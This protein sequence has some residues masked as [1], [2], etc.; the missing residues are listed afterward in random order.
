MKLSQ[1][2]IS[3]VAILTILLLSLQSC[4]SIVLVNKKGV[5]TPDPL[6]NEIGFYNGKQVV[7]IDTTI[8]LKLP[9][10]YVFVHEK[11][12]EGGFHSVEYRVT[13]GGVLLS[14]V[15]F[16]KKRKVKVK[17]TCLKEKN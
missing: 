2:N 3:V 4:Y 9:E 12:A 11:C 14:A 1:S 17:Y 16:G 5:P 6:N 10:N 15:T 8:T 7:I 13:L